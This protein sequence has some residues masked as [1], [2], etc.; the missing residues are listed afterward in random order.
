[1]STR[2]SKI[3]YVCMSRCVCLLLVHHVVHF[4][5]FE[6]KYPVTAMVTAATGIHRIHFPF[7]PQ[8][9]QAPIQQSQDKADGYG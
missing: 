6:S 4:E 8:W 9:A 7:L 1:M 3:D 5:V 2:L